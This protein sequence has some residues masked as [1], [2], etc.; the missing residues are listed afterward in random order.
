M[1]QEISMEENA[2]KLAAEELLKKIKSNQPEDLTSDNDFLGTISKGNMIAAFLKSLLNRKEND[3]QMIALYGEWGSGKTSLMQYVQSQLG[4]ESFKPKFFEAWKLENDDNLSMSL[5]ECILDDELSLG[6]LKKE[7]WSAGKAIVKGLIDSTTL[8]PSIAG[9]SIVSVSGEKFRKSVDEYL[10]NGSFS[11]KVKDFERKYQNM[12]NEI[13]SKDQRLVV[14]VDDL[15]RCE[16]E[17]VLNLLSAIKLF[18][19]LGNRTIFICGLD[20]KAVDEAVK[21]KYGEVIKSGEYMEK[22]FDISFDMPKPDINK[23]I[24]YYFKDLP[25][26]DDDIIKVK[27]FFEAMHFTNPRHIKKVLNKY[28]MVR[29]YQITMDKEKLIPEQSIAF[30]RYL[31]LFIIILSKFNKVASNEFSV[32]RDYDEKV[33][34]WESQ[35]KETM[36]L[37][38]WELHNLNFYQDKEYSTLNQIYNVHIKYTDHNKEINKLELN[39]SFIIKII[40]L[41]APRIEAILDVSDSGYCK[42]FIKHGN[43]ENEIGYAAYFCNYINQNP[44]ILQNGSGEIIPEIADSKYKLWNIF[45]MAELYL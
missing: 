35:W 36:Q 16:P 12:E 14:F 22:V 21:V 27:N 44:Q 10:E 25:E 45:K 29:Y 30:F 40:S 9:S 11:D 8:K 26:N 37:Q 23:M 7:V 6:I 17:N 18:F 4:K 32:I 34:Q 33:N 1:G 28:L 39:T 20:K 41:F 31:T 19:T 38:I 3:I 42:Q 15:D 13:L 24:E 43:N 5:L 2:R